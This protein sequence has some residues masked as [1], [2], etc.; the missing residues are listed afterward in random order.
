VLPYFKQ[1]ETNPLLAAR[2]LLPTYPG[3]FQLDVALNILPRVSWILAPL[4]ESEHPPAPEEY[5][6]VV[7]ANVLHTL[8][9]H[10]SVWSKTALFITHDENGG[11][12]DHVPPP[13]APAATPGE[14]ITASPLPSD[15]GGVAGP[16]GLGFRVPLM[17]ASPFARGGFVSHDTFD[18]TSL[19]RFLETR[20]GAEVPNLSSWRR[21]VTGDLTS[22]FNFANVNKSVPA[23]PKPSLTDSRILTSSCA[24]G[25]PLSLIAE[26]SGISSL[27]QLEMEVVPQYPITVNSAPPPQ[28][29]GTAPAPSGPVPCTK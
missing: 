7:A 18:H 4:L 9:S 8:V 22:A 6:E 25:A 14:F 29:P 11:F 23:L 12:F 24:A 5:G 27:Q 16:I 15:A 19:L 17:I 26:N 13:V 3:T 2:A 20:F 21:S 28:E 1:Y 10:P